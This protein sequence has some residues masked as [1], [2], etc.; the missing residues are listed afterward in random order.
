MTP[1]SLRRIDGRAIVQRD[2]A[3]FAC[4]VVR[5]EALRLPSTLAHYRA[6]GVDRFL[7][8]DNDSDD[9]SREL[10]E[11]QPDVHLFG[12]SDSFA[13]SGCGVD[14]IHAVLGAFAEGQWVVTADADELLIYPYYETVDLPRFCRFLDGDGAQ[15]LFCLMVDMYSDRPLAETTLAP[16]GSLIEACPFFDSGP[17]QLSR[18]SVF[19]YRMAFG[20]LRA[21]LFRERFDGNRRPPQIS[22]VPLV[23]W[24]AG[25][26]YLA[27][28][29][30]MTPVPLAQTTGALLHFKFL[31]DFAARV[32]L[33]AERGQHFAGAREYRDY[34]VIVRGGLTSL[35]AD[36]SV[37]FKDGAQLVPMRIMQT[38]PAYDAYVRS[39]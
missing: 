16:W 35:M 19:P 24:G 22:K 11:S 38:S 17:Y 18:H 13:A 2:G 1:P 20:G 30:H 14:W 29:H 31:S 4:L 10:L 7:D 21:R 37:S 6:I 27:N 23:R 28:A 36:V 8:I 15:G 39:Q 9:G 25:T 3:V 5:N 26:R 32:E 12:T 34:R 33:E